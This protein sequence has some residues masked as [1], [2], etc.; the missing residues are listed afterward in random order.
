[1]R[2]ALGAGRGRLVRQLLTESL[3][4]A[5]AGGTVGVVLASWL[6]GSFNVVTS[7][8]P[9]SL[10]LNLETDLRM[11][12]Y[13]AALTIVATLVCGLV[14]ARG[15]S[16]FDVVSSL[17]D[18]N[19]GATGPRRMRRALVVGQVAA[20][21]ALLIWSGL[22]VRSLGRINDVDPGFEPTGVLLAGIELERN[23]GEP[24][25]RNLVELQQRIADL[26]GRG[27]G[28]AGE[29]R[30]AGDGRTGGVRCVDRRHSS[31]LAPPRH[32]QQTGPGWFD[33][34]ANPVHRRPRLHVERSPGCTD[35]RD[36]QRNAGQTVLEWRCARQAD[37]V[38]E[39]AC[40]SGGGRARQQ[41]L[42]AR[43]GDRADGLPPVPPGNGLEHDTPHPHG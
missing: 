11:L 16:R 12:M 38:S 22:F 43:R 28:G 6:A 37:H 39:T 10:E 21:A 7:S 35:G 27:V 19:S 5:I 40:R 3:V 42:D 29:D 8:L 2:L 1:M 30:P 20:S 17:K 14:P 9:V 32:R 41:I 13:S 4:L 23:A 24:A 25:E 34:R 31:L 18:S 36:R 15:A 26:A 33:D